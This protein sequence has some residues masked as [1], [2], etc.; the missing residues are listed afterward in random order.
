MGKKKKGKKKPRL[1]TELLIAVASVV[2]AIAA[3][4][5]VVLDFIIKVLSLGN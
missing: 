3:L 4:L 5:D 1:N 2:T